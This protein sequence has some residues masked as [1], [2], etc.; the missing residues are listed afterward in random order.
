VGL[1]GIQD[2]RTQ[3]VAG[4]AI[5][6]IIAG[7]ICYVYR[8]PTFDYYAKEGKTSRAPMQRKHH[9]SDHSGCPITR[10]RG[11]MWGYPYRRTPCLESK[12]PG[13]VEFPC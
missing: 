1:I 6:M 12:I 13:T 9:V 3:L 7:V 4:S 5:L 8:E 10:N 2:F 11:C